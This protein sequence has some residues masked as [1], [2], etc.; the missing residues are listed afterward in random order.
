MKSE[1]IGT[2]YEVKSSQTF[3]KGLKKAVKQGK[4]IEKLKAVVYKLAN[5]EPLEPKYHDHNLVNDKYYKN[6]REC[7]IEPDWL[8]IY[9][10]IEDELIL[11]LVNTG[12]H[13]NLF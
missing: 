5:K 9:Q 6:V 13:S 10:Y 3:D 12:S 2:K 7:H 4:N 11:L 1:I 8:L